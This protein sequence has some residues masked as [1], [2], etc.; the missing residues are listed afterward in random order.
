MRTIKSNCYLVKILISIAY[1]PVDR[2]IQTASKG[3]GERF[4]VTR[5]SSGGLSISSKS[6]EILACG[7]IFLDDC[8]E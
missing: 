1:M 6:V 5:G 2:Y 4:Y 3:P 8:D 7:V